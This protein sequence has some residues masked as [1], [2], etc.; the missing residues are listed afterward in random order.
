M[1]RNIL[2]LNRNTLTI[3]VGVFLIFSSFVLFLTLGLTV[4]E[5]YVNESSFKKTTCSVRA[6]E[7]YK[8]NSKEDWYRCP[9][10]C[11]I[12][13]TQDGLK[14]QCELSEFP[15]LR[16]VVDVST[17]HGLKSAI[18]HESPDKMQKYPDCST[19]YCDRDSLVNEKMVNRFQ[20]AYGS[21]GSKYPC[22]YDVQSLQSDDYDDDGQEHALIRLTYGPASFVN[23]IIWPSVAFIAG[24]VCVIYGFYMLLGE[25]KTAKNGEKKKFLSDL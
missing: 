10:R 8:M 1:R 20:K 16:V 2:N 7:V 12:A 14:T 6:V 19:Y 5:S 11:T 22:Y 9:W 24:V 13:H 21:I 25:K 15:C 18:L 17:K 23:S 4:M 3:A